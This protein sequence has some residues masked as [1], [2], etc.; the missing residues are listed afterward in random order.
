M[1]QLPLQTLSRQAFAPFGEVIMLEGARHYPINQG[2]TERFH[3]LAMADT[4]TQDGKTIL[5]VFRAQPRALPLAIEVMECH[6]LG[7]Q[8][9]VP[10]TSDKDDEYLVVVAPPGE[11]AA[12]QMQAFICKGLQG[13]NYA[14]GVWHHPLIALHKQS[15]FIVMDRIGEGFNCDEIA[16]DGSW[17]VG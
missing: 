15:D 3:A 13:V 1:P 12:D 17:T 11:F 7:S 9:F 16:L 14:R 5:S 10:L 4:Q 2:T 8:A 6:P